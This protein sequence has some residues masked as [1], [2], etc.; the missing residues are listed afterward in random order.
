MSTSPIT[1][2]VLDTATGQ[3]AAGMAVVLKH[4]TGQPIQGV[5]PPELVERYPELNGLVEVA[6]IRVPTPTASRTFFE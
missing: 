2:H 5:Y 4:L 6:P 3:P 1:T